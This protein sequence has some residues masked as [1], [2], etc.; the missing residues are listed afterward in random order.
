MYFLVPLSVIWWFDNYS[1]QFKNIFFQFK[2]P[3]IFQIFFFG[4]PFK[5]LKNGFVS[6]TP[7]E[8]ERRRSLIA[9]IAL[10]RSLRSYFQSNSRSH[11]NLGFKRPTFYCFCIE[12][13]IGDFLG[14]WTEE[15]F[16]V[17]F[18]EY[19]L[20]EKRC[21]MTQDFHRGLW[22]WQIGTSWL[23]NDCTVNTF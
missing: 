4:R 10:A 22:S 3:I 21:K 8:R 17:P 15:D 6:M 19:F 9:L 1:R 11:W 16:A 7:P 23:V 14:I 13:R 18:Q 20:A 12:E 2:I 5:I